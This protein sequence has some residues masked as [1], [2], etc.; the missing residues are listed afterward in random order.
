MFYYDMILLSFRARLLRQQGRAA[1]KPSG[2]FAETF[3]VRSSSDQTRQTFSNNKRSLKHDS[4]SSMRPS[5]GAKPGK[6]A[7]SGD[8]AGLRIDGKVSKSAQRPEPYT[9]VKGTVM[10]EK[11]GDWEISLANGGQGHLRRQHMIQRVHAGDQLS[12]F[13]LGYSPL[14]TAGKAAIATV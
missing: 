6:Y 1:V 7:A 10:A 3:L 9:P 2:C 13:I 14:G 8:R 5:K 11:D 4:T 12:F